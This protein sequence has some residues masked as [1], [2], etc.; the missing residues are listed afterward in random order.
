M[1]MTDEPKEELVLTKAQPVEMSKVGRPTQ[2]TTEVHR[3]IMSAIHAGA[4]AWV[5]AASAGIPPSTY[6]RWMARGAREW[7]EH[8]QIVEAWHEQHAEGED[9]PLP[10]IFAAFWYDV[11]RAQ[12]LCRLAVERQ[13]RK[14]NPLAWLRHGP[15]R[16]RPGEPGWTD[17]NKVELTGPDGGPVVVAPG[18][19][20]LKRLSDGD[21][22]ALEAT[23][24]RALPG[25][26]GSTG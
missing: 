21:L 14:D 25:P 24:A 4:F 10:T 15:G 3:L 20:D 17:S 1:M 9:E 6:G 11:K 13:V 8:E 12:A 5:A 7:A 23:L 18:Q 2:L 16:D 22:D 26:S 19:F